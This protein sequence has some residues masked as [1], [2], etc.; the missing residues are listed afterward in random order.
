MGGGGGYRVLEPGIGI[1][2]VDTEFCVVVL[3]SASRAAL[4]CDTHVCTSED[5]SACR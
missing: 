5:D 2:G 1:G 4:S 3:M